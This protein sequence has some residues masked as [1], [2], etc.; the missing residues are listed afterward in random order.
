M[1]FTVTYEDGRKVEAVA[2]P[3]DIVL[4][5]QRYATSF[6]DFGRQTRLEWLYFL[7][8]S[9]LNRAGTEPRPFEDFLAAVEEVEAVEEAPA[10]P[11][12]PEASD[13]SSPE[14]PAEAA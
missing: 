5:E 9:P 6:M 14:S 2:K 1:A 8:W 7:A 10:A 13:V 4:F 11:F 3:R 12:E